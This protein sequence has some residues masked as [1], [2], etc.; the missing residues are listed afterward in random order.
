MR[1]TLLTMILAT[2]ASLT[3]DVSS[4]ICW[5]ALDSLLAYRYEAGNC[6]ST[7]PTLTKT[8]RISCRDGCGETTSINNYSIIGFGDCA[9]ANSGCVP[10]VLLECFPVEGA[11]I[12][13]YNPPSFHTSI[14]NARGAGGCNFLRCESATSST[15]SAY[16][17]CDPN[18]PTYG[19]CNGEPRSPLIANLEGGPLRLTDQDHG[20][21]FDLNADGIPE[22]TAWTEGGAG[23]A[24][25]AM[26]RN[27]NGIIDNG[28][29]LF[30]DSS[31]QFPSAMRNGVL[32]LAIFDDSLSRG[33]E[34]GLIDEK[35]VAFDRLLLWTDMNHNGQSESHELEPLAAELQALNLSFTASD[36]I[37][38]SGHQ[39]R[40]K[41]LAR[42]RDG[43]HVVIWDVFF[44]GD[45]EQ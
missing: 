6:P 28:R 32:A 24:F 10:T 29:E 2:L 11:D 7:T 26:D 45:E 40:Y 39:F 15:M 4:A 33:N 8:Y 34:D 1:T 17:P 12:H 27:R 36:R 31:P 13:G 18:A 44:V 3:P 37:D 42:R 25:L 41:S 9:G 5:G 22:Q 35:D 30:G 43:G 14:I 21:L 19:D 16:C 23:A 38:P 20:V